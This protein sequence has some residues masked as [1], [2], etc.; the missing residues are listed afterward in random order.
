MCDFFANITVP[1]EAG[2]AGG[3]LPPPHCVQMHKYLHL[4]GVFG[5]FWNIYA[6]TNVCGKDIVSWASMVLQN[7]QNL[8][9]MTL[10]MIYIVAFGGGLKRPRKIHLNTQWG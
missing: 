3:Q 6:P 1:V 5:L 10:N 2:C 4:S 9:E 7:Y 8:I